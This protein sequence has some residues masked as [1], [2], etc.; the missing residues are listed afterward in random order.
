MEPS[1]DRG[2]SPVD[3]PV[4]L[5]GVGVGV[6]PGDRVGAG[7]DEVAGVSL[8]PTEDAGVSPGNGDSAGVG[9]GVG[10]GVDFGSTHTGAAWAGPAA[11]PVDGFV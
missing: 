9:V 1:V 10:V 7:W 11:T 2:R 6:D 5:Y 3:R 8:G 4:G